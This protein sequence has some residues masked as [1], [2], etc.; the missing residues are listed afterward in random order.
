MRG[1]VRPSGHAGS[2]R[3]RRGP[4]VYRASDHVIGDGG[5]G[6]RSIEID[7][8]VPWICNLV[9]PGYEDDKR[10]DLGL[11]FHDHIA[12]HAE[13]NDGTERVKK[14]AQRRERVFAHVDRKAEREY[15]V[16]DG[17][18]TDGRAALTRHDPPGHSIS[19]VSRGD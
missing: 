6:N 5:I 14:I 10:S 19:E 8:L 1:S 16:D 18:A 3:S 9:E 17:R 12:A 2:A 13:H 15:P 11:P 4:L 7:Q